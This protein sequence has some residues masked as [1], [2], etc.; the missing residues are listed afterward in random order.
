M[1]QQVVL[2]TNTDV[3]YKNVSRLNDAISDI[4]KRYADIA[5]VMANMPKYW[6][7]DASDK[8]SAEVKKLVEDADPLIRMIAM[9]PVEL[10]Q[11]AGLYATVEDAN[12]GLGATL[13][14]NVID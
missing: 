8:H 9:K 13:E 11:I 3:L 4:R 2:K 1:S 5:S 10:M 12:K 6:L 14:S 7:G